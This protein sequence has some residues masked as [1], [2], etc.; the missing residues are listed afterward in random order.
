MSGNVTCW[1]AVRPTTAAIGPPTTSTSPFDHDQ[2][3]RCADWLAKTF[4]TL[5]RDEWAAIFADTD[6]CV[7]PV[8]TLAEAPEHP[9]HR[10]RQSFVEIDDI[11]VATTPPRFSNTPA[12]P[13][14]VGRP[15]ADTDAI[16]DELGITTAARESLR[17]AGVIA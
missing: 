16:L 8:L 15:S 10:A 17:T 14:D 9:H 4:R 11:T 7:A 5:P 6:S 3:E 1:T 2:T 13:G 12:A